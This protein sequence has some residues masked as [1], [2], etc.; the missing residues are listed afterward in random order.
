MFIYLFFYNF[1]SFEYYCKVLK[2]H[3]IIC[4]FSGTNSYSS[5]Y[6]RAIQ[7]RRGFNIFGRPQKAPQRWYDVPRDVPVNTEATVSAVIAVDEKK[8]VRS[9]RAEVKVEPVEVKAAVETTFVDPP[10]DQ[11]VLVKSRPVAQI[12]ADLRVE[13]REFMQA[14]RKLVKK[15]LKKDSYKVHKFNN[16]DTDSAITVYRS[17]EG[18][19]MIKA[20]N[21]DGIC[22]KA[23]IHKSRKTIALIYEQ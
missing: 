14:E 3:N 9:S 19:A 1:T 17:R 2:I 15:Y 5:S 21:T 13:C 6:W 18:K 7:A 11:V 16:Q 4:F 23:V 20:V 12:Q 8:E 10:A 22:V